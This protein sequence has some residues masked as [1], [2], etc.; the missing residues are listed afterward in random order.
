MV[1]RGLKRSNSNKAGAGRP[2][3]LHNEFQFI[4]WCRHSHGA[5]WAAEGKQLQSASCSA[6]NT[7]ELQDTAWWRPKPEF[8]LQG[9]ISNATKH[10]LIGCLCKALIHC[11]TRLLKR[12]HRMKHLQCSKQAADCAVCAADTQTVFSVQHNR[13]GHKPPQSLPV[14]YDCSLWCWLITTCG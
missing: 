14:T 3:E 11:S 5:A 4:V 7:E 13:P 12:A 10:M 8:T 9:C 2:N 1:L 6:G